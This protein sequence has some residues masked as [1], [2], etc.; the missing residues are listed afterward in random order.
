[1]NFLG[2]PKIVASSLGVALLK[3][4]VF[5]LHEHSEATVSIVFLIA[6]ILSVITDPYLDRLFKIVAFSYGVALLK[7]LDFFPHKHFE[8][9]FSIVCLIAVI[10]AMLFCDNWPLRGLFKIV[11]FSLGVALRMFP[12]M[13]SHVHFEATFSIVC[14]TAAISSVIT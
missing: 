7:L 1:M 11:A 6:A 10:A 9:A 5:F 13:V 3:L 4:P 8:A 2:L 12:D 14:P